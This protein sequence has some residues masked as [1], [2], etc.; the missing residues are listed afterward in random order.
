[1]GLLDDLYIGHGASFGGQGGGLLDFLRTTQ[2]QQD[3]YQPSAG[4]PG[5]AGPMP[6]ASPIGIGGYQMPRI[7][8][9]SQF[10]PPPQDPAALP[11]NAQPTQG[12]LPVQPQQSQQPQGFGGFLQ[13][14]NENFQNMGNGGSLIGALTGQ[15]PNNQTAQFLVAKGI[16]P[17]MAKTIASDPGLLRSVLPSL[18]GTGGQTDDIK[19]YQFAKKE[20]PSLTFEKFMQQKK[21]VSG[22]YSLT[23][24][25]GTNEKGETVM[26]QTGKSGSAI[27]T[28]LPAG[29]KLSSGVDKIDLGSNWGI[30]DKK[31][32]QMV[33]QQAK[34][35]EG[36]EAAEERG[37]AK[38]L[39]QVALPNVIANAEQ[40]LQTIKSIKE[41]PYRQRGTGLSSVFNAIPA[42]GG[43][44]FA[45]KLEQLKGKTFLEAF[46]QLK[47]GGAITEIEGKKAE[48][49]IARL[50][51]GQSE[52]AFLEAV[53]ELETI[54]TKGIERAKVR[55]GQGGQ[56][57]ATGGGSS[58][59]GVVEGATATNPQTGQKLTFR[60]GKWQ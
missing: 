7:G 42:T 9:M 15:R 47:G 14:I 1:V 23:P 39:A 26:V 54:V 16:D 57:E 21:A 29:V 5:Q 17:A 43:Y 19:E 11:P 24:Q 4:F 8:E 38:G 30:I 32:G 18:L 53:N 20:N 56:P 58:T 41:D 60:N 12:Q 34:D 28:V 48:S 46:Q 55:A 37:K 52:G 22:E 2:M 51:A 44:D 45:Q 31:T 25:F 13:G 59:S 36:K 10:T 27:Q 50:S 40:T 3:Q 35:I 49:A 33:G 6:Q